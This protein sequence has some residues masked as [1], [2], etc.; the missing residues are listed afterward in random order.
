MS[1]SYLSLIPQRELLEQI[2]RYRVACNFR[3]VGMPYM[4]D[5]IIFLV[6]IATANITFDFGFI[7][8]N[9]NELRR[10][11]ATMD[12]GIGEEVYIERVI[13]ISRTGASLVR[14]RTAQQGVDFILHRGQ[15]VLLTVPWCFE[16]R[17]VFVQ[18]LAYLDAI[19]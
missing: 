2:E 10:F 3:V 1:R 6:Y 12:V 13:H 4:P 19:A 8:I 14:G 5:S 15:F 16:L 9:R 11:I 7:P 17:E 18:A